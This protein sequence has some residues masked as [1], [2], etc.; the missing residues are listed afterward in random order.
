MKSVAAVSKTT[1]TLGIEWSDFA[2][3]SYEQGM[4]AAQKLAQATSPQTALE[5]QTE[6]LKASYER[7]VVQ[8]KVTGELYSGLAKEMTQPFAALVPKAPAV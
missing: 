1:Q 7:L 4:A 5:I 2:K 8:A 3:Q 6:F